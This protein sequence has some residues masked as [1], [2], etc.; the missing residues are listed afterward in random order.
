MSEVGQ[1]L[2]VVVPDAAWSALIEI[3]ED[4]AADQRVRERLG[5]GGLRTSR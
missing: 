4:I 2:A 3:A 5:G 1:P